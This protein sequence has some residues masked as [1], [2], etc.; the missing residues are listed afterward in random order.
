MSNTNAD[1]QGPFGP[2]VNQVLHATAVG[3]H[4]DLSDVC[5]R[6]APG[7]ALLARKRAQFFD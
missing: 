6:V 3:R 1:I 5:G 2:G 7:D 4:T